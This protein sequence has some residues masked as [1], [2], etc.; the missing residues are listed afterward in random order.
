[1]EVDR[2]QQNSGLTGPQGRTE[3]PTKLVLFKF[4]SVK[5]FIFL[6]FNRFATLWLPCRKN[7][8]KNKTIYYEIAFVSNN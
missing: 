8:S 2:D 5:L 7:Y 6:L 4:H 3:L 1:M